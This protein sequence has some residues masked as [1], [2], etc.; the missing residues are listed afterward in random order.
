MRHKVSAFLCSFYKLR[1]REKRNYYF[2]PWTSSETV[3]FLRPFARRAA[4]TRRPLAVCIRWRKPCLLFLLRLW[5][6]NVLFIFCYAIFLF[7][8]Y[9]Y[10]RA[11]KVSTNHFKVGLVSNLGLSLRFEAPSH[12]GVQSYENFCEWTKFVAW[13]V[14]SFSVLGISVLLLCYLF[15]L[16][17]SMIALGDYKSALKRLACSAMSSASSK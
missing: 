9:T 5:G 12:F 3:N 16:F 4:N 7:F 8:W 1:C 14:V 2:L 10:H 6:W 15:Y 13:K 17:V 11:G